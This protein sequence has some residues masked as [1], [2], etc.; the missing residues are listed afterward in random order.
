[1]SGGP[2]KRIVQVVADGTPGGG[3]TF[4]L[5]LVE[6][7]AACR[8][9]GIATYVVCQENSHLL[10]RAQAL[11]VEVFGV[12]FFRRRLDPAIALQL[13]SI[14]KRISPNVVHAHGGR[15]AFSLSFVPRSCP[16][17]QLIYTVHGY[18]FRHQPLTRRVLGAAAERW[19]SSR[20]NT[21]IFV[22]ES[23]HQLA[24]NWRLVTPSTPSQ[25]IRNAIDTGRIP[26][27]HD[28]RT[29]LIAFSGRL[30]PQKDPLLFVDIARELAGEGYSF[31]MLGSGELETE[32]RNRVA[33]Y[34]L[35]PVLKLHTGLSREAAFEMLRG[36]SACVLTSRWEG[37]PLVPLEAM[38]M[39]VAVVAAQVDSMVEIIES[40][41]NGFLVPGRSP[42]MF[43]AAI[44][45]LTTNHELHTSVE[46][47]ARNRILERFSYVRFL[48]QY[49]A[50][51]G[52]AGGPP[53]DDNGRR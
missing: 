30:T 9:Q 52:L 2:N 46:Q 37:L 45:I 8:A 36:A 39:G 5:A 1:M 24:R 25:V 34:G 33:T 49:W 14:V 42:R 15:A 7:L 12:D 50:L 38:A 17:W 18:H 27:V 32:V 23:D 6:A 35:E 51:Y 48:T 20:V 47:C 13:W 53:A 11:G 22:S 43:A 26:R 28:R 16:H 21:T 31:I 10:R 3:T 29:R 40:G 41:V 19:I 4:V 44:R